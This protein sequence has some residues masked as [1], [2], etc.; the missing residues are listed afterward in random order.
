MFIGNDVWT[1]Y[2]YFQP[3]EY[4]GVDGSEKF[5]QYMGMEVASAG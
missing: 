4:T 1:D 3:T 5:W 2:K